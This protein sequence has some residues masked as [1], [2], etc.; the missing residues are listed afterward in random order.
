MPSISPIIINNLLPNV[1]VLSA[2]SGDSGDTAV[3]Y[4]Q[5]KQ[6]LGSYVYDAKNIYLY[7][8]NFQQLTGVINYNTFDTNG[9]KNVTNITPTVD[10]YQAFSSLLLSTENQN[11]PIIFNGNSSISATILPLTTVEVQF[12]TNRI[13]NSDLSQGEVEIDEAPQSEEEIE[14]KEDVV[15]NF[16]GQKKEPKKD[17]DKIVLILLILAAASIVA[18]LYKKD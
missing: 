1:T 7:S 18:Y 5:I 16:D 4:N 6:S 8:D 14:T 10:P 9:N 11:L 2:D 12:L 13:K 17:S 15:I 3:S